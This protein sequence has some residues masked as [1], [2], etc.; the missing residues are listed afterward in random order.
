M[1]LVR[2]LGWIYSSR[3]CVC[4]SMSGLLNLGRTCPLSA[5]IEHKSLLINK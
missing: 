2:G 1:I 5:F 3:Q 4:V